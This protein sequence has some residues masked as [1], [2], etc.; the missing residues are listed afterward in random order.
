MK[1]VLTSD[2]T[3]VSNYINGEE[4]SL[5][6]L[7]AR[8]QQRIYSFI[9]SKVYD[10][11]VAEDVFQDTFIKVIKT[12]KRGAYNEEGKFLPWVMRIAHNLVIDHFRRNNRM[13]KFDNDGEFSIFSV[14]SDSGLNVEKQ[15]IKDQVES[16]VRRLIEELP[17]DQKEVLMMRMYQDMSFKEISERTGV[18]INT[19]LGRMRY[20]LINLRKVIEKHNIVLTN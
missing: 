19:A 20:A 5:S 18:S 10:R 9:Y 4:N 2:A 14:L 17:G 11:D 8:H 6:I 12:L 13:P 1:N 3:L 16:D 15:L 7:I